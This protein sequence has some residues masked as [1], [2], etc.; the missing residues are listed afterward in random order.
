[1]KQSLIILSTS[2]DRIQFIKKYPDLIFFKIWIRTDPDLNE[3]LSS[4]NYSRLLQN[5]GS[6]IDLY[7]IL[8]KK[9]VCLKIGH[10]WCKKIESL[11]RLWKCNFS[12]DKI[13][14]HKILF[15]FV[16]NLCR[17]NFLQCEIY[18]LI[19]YNIKTFDTH[20]AEPKSVTWQE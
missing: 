9:K 4:A 12:R 3:L 18:I 7:P 19:I 17:L 14:P 2:N 11:H 10:D 20:Q 1:M 15:S 16:H 13:S 6:R 8:S 5:R